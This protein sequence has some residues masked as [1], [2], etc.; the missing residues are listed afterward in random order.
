MEDFS[1]KVF[2]F[3]KKRIESQYPVGKREAM[4]IFTKRKEQHEAFMISRSEDVLGRGEIL[5]QIESYL[6]D[7]STNVPFLILGNAGSGKSSIL[8][9][10][11]QNVIEKIKRHEIKPY[12][13]RDWRLFCHFVGAVP[14]ST[15]ID[16]T[17]LHY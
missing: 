4:D 15:A 6:Y 2:N 16:G 3:F 11:G 5:K 8:A 10:S 12:K 17:I 14:G 7:S 13:N 9:K 1:T